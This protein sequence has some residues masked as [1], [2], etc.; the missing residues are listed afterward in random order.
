MN[1]K[2]TSKEELIETGKQLVREN[3][4]DALNIRSL[5]K[6]CGIASGSIYN[7][8]SSKEGLMVCIVE[9]IWDEIFDF[10]ILNS[11]K[12]IVLLVED[13]LNAIE[14]GKNLYPNFSCVHF[15]T[16][17]KENLGQ[18]KTKMLS[19]VEKLKMILAS[20]LKYNNTKL[21][22]KNINSKDFVDI[23]FNLIISQFFMAI[24]KKSIIEM[25]KTLTGE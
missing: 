18:G 4:V 7:Y 12:H 19:Y 25:V 6:K 2:V 3:G 17:S 13:V 10:K 9:S 16:F 1:Q 8:F 21:S 11:R 15:L 5:S 22:G 23:L 14:T 24:D 20:S